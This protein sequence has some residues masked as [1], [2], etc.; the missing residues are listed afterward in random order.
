MTVT[1]FPSI[2]KAL[3]KYAITVPAITALVG[4]RVLDQ[5]GPDVIFPFMV[6]R[7][8][9]SRARQ[10][11]WL[12][13]V[14]IEVQGEEHRDVVNATSRAELICETGVAVLNG[15]QNHVLD[16]CVIAGPIA[17]TG[18]RLVP[19]QLAPGITYPRYVGEVTLTYHPL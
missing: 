10:V 18:P 19:D 5:S 7:K 3:L 17:T 4:N 8:L 16:G 9:S 12:E 13:T 6:M 1:V 14:T 2:E 11:R 15:L